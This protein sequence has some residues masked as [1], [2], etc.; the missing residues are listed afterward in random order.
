MENHCCKRVGT[1]CSTAAH[2]F[3]QTRVMFASSVDLPSFYCRLM[4]SWITNMKFDCRFVFSRLPLRLQHR[5]VKLAFENSLNDFLFPTSATVCSRADIIPL[6][7]LGD[8]RCGK[9]VFSYYFSIVVSVS[10]SMYKSGWLIV[11][12]IFGTTWLCT[13]V[14]LDLVLEFRNPLSSDRQHLSYDV[15][16]QVRGKII[17]TVLCCIVY[18]SCAQS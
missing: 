6:D 12:W 15:C 7:K 1:L 13:C 14:I 4:K 8:I 3:F 17:R 18:W 11:D 2:C 5:A 10:W 16:L 9:R